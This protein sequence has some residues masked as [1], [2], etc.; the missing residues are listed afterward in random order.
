MLVGADAGAIGVVIEL[1]EVFAPPEKH[2]L[3]RGEQGVDGDEQGF[4][5]AVD[6]AYRGL[7]PVEL[8][9]ETSHLAVAEDEVLREGSGRGSLSGSLPVFYGHERLL[10]EA[11]LWLR[12]SFCAHLCTSSNRHQVRCVSC[13]GWVQG[14]ERLLG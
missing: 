10:Q 2:G 12:R 13:M 7:A 11:G 6:G 1:N 9:G 4:G 3:A 14:M 5:P 8:T